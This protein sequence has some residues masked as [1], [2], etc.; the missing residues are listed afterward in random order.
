MQYRE[1]ER[2]ACLTIMSI[3]FNFVLFVYQTI[4]LIY[5]LEL[6]LKHL[7]NHS[8]L[9]ILVLLKLTNKLL[10]EFFHVT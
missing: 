4:L 5:R 2:G 10:L 6:V 3:N 9:L 7:A 8:I 1:L